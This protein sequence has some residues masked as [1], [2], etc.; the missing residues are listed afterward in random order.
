[1]RDIWNVQVRATAGMLAS[2]MLC[3]PLFCEA[4]EQGVPILRMAKQ[5]TDPAKD[6]GGTI[7]RYH[8]TWQTDVVKN[9][10]GALVR[11]EPG[12]WRKPAAGGNVRT[13]PFELVPAKKVVGSDFPAQGWEQPD[14][15]DGAWTRNPGQFDGYYRSLAMIAVRGKFQV[16]DPASA[17]EMDLTV[18]FHGGAVAY[19]NGKEIGREGLP[20]GKITNETLANDYP[21]ETDD[22]GS[23]KQTSGLIAQVS[24]EVVHKEAADKLWG[25][26]ASDKA[27]VAEHYRQ[28]FRTLQVKVSAAALRKGVNVLA[29][30]VHRAPAHPI[31]FLAPYNSY[32]L[33][34][35]VWSRCLVDDIQLTAKSANGFVPNVARP[36][37]I[38]VWNASM[39][40]KL[41][42]SHFGDPN[43]AVRPV[44][45][46]GIRN[47][48]FSGQIVVSSTTPIKGFGVT[49]MD[50]KSKDGQTIPA[51][52]VMIGF[53][54]WDFCCFNLD[55]AGIGISS[56]RCALYNTLDLA[57]PKEIAVGTKA[58]NIG[59]IR[60]PSYPVAMQPI[61][62]SVRVPKDA[63]AGE[64]AGKIMIA[65]DGK[66][67][68]VPLQVKV[69][70]EWALPDSQK[71]KT[72][73]GMVESPDSVAL[74]YNVKMWSEEHWKLLDKVFALMGEVGVDDLYIPML[75]KTNLG[76]E[77][78]MV[79]WVQQTDGSVK[80][81]FTI[82]ARYLD[83]A[84]KYLGK[85]LCVVCW[86]HEMPF[87]RGGSSRTWAGKSIAVNRGDPSALAGG[88][89]IPYTK[90]DA[91]GKATEQEAPQW[92]TPESKTFWRPVVEGMKAVL[93]KRG[94]EKT[95]LFGCET[96]GAFIPQCKDDFKAIAP[97]IHWYSR[98]HHVYNIKDLSYFN[99][100]EHPPGGSDVMTVNWSPDTSDTPYYRWRS[101]AWKSMIPTVSGAWSMNMSADP[102]LF[103]LMAESILL[104]KNGWSGKGS[105]T[106][107]V[108]HGIGC[109]GADYWPVLT[110]AKGDCPY[111][112]SRYTDQCGNMDHF[113]ATYAFL[114]AGKEAPAA[115]GHLRLLQE[116]LQD[117]EARIFVQDAV[118]DQ[119]NK[120][121]VDLVKRCN[122]VCDERT[123]RLYYYSLYMESREEY[124]ETFPRD[125]FDEGW[126]RQNTEQLYAL[127]GEVAKTLGP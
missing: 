85:Q 87:S 25:V 45:L 47:G 20:A 11:V 119:K 89:P 6:C 65:A 18:S 70:G 113:S 68:E 110:P 81:D 14:F 40:A 109:Q 80:P 64:Y 102:M 22:G 123:R 36:A 12:V 125:S 104:H 62:V 67:V 1:M 49:A 33:G 63:K 124:R 27:A 91:S 41:L 108:V 77:E 79:K 76:N 103:R 112:L 5:W 8:E 53:E 84:T 83:V 10:S 96:D 60:V 127:A 105:E 94:M 115:T 21:K 50:L 121:G 117:M 82:V 100:G 107:E 54:Q 86:V 46:A 26:S 42:P 16:S 29:I 74:K 58:A 37:G 4:A 2:I 71:F 66:T 114:G 48:T 3:F 97:D 32:D 57:G 39:F 116:S 126:Y 98:A 44:R 28:R 52:A 120:L 101:P 75:A 90:V 111:N 43:E 69:V 88:F 55:M 9:D 93:A 24:G 23:S 13:G 17:S 73:V 106:T 19:L 99:W 118:L 95:M 122:E 59:G 78:S 51:S 56:S 31:M 92:G 35:F 61:C 7:W 15:D 34:K 72:F 30:E 38:Q